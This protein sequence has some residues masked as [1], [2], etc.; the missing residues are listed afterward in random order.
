[1]ITKYV[2]DRLASD[3]HDELRK[4]FYDLRKQVMALKNVHERLIANRSFRQFTPGYFIKKK[5]LFRVNAFSGDSFLVAL[6]ITN[7]L[8]HYVSDEQGMNQLFVEQI[9]ETEERDGVKSVQFMITDK[10]DVKSLVRIVALQ[11]RLFLGY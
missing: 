2:V 6:E 1:M 10:K 4:L 8:E 3:L 11:H 5:E 7:K 9:K